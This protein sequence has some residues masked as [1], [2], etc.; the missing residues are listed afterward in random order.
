MARIL[1]FELITDTRLENNAKSLISE[2]LTKLENLLNIDG[3]KLTHGNTRT[4]DW[5]DGT[6]QYRVYCC[7]EKNTRERSWSDIYE[8]INSVKACVY[9]F[10]K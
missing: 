1:S 9:R 8:I 4:F 2:Y 3:V 7:V 6:Y 10:I 5:R